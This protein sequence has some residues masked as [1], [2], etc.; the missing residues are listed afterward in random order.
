MREARS[1][2]LLVTTDGNLE[3][4]ISSTDIS[5]WLQRQQE[6]GDSL[7]TRKAVAEQQ[8]MEIQSS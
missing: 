7:P 6:F 2:R 3:G 5:N 1:R 8:V 4:I